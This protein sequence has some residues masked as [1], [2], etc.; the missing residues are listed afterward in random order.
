M[1]RFIPLICLFFSLVSAEDFFPTTTNDDSFPLV[2][3]EG[4]PNAIIA[5]C[6]N[7]ITGDFFDRQCDLMLVGGEPLVL[8]RSYSSSDTSQGGLCN[9]WHFNLQGILECAHGSDQYVL[10]G[11]FGSE[12]RFGKLKGN[13]ASLSKEMFKKG[14]TNNSSA[15]I[16]GK[17]NLKNYLLKCSD[18][19]A[20]HCTLIKGDGSCEIFKRQER[21]YHK[22]AKAYLLQVEKKAS[23][24]ERHYHYNDKDQLSYVAMVSG[25]S[26]DLPVDVLQTL[27]FE[28]PSKSLN[29]TR[30]RVASGDGRSVQY[31]FSR[32]KADGNR[33]SYLREVQRPNAPTEKY[34]YEKFDGSTRQ[35]LIEKRVGE[36]VM[37][38]CYCKT[39]PNSALLKGKDRN[40]GKV[41]TLF[42]PIG[43][44][45]ALLPLYN[46]HYDEPDRDRDGGVCHVFDAHKIRTKYTWDKNL[47]LV[48][49]EKMNSSDQL[50]V[51]D[52]LYWGKGGNV[53]NLV[54]RVYSSAETG[55]LFCK[56]YSYDQFGNIFKE[57][58]YGHLTGKNPVALL[59]D[60]NGTP[61]E[62]GCD[63]HEKSF[64]YSQDGRNLLL[65]ETEG[66]R[67]TAYRYYDGTDLVA[68][69]YI[70][71]QGKI[72][73]RYCYTYDSNSALASEIVDDGTSSEPLDLSNVTYRKLRL[74]TPRKTFPFGVPDTEEEYYQDSS[75]QQILL[76]ALVNT[77]SLEGHL[78][79][80]DVYDSNRAFRYTLFW[81]Y[82]HLGQ[83]TKEVDALGQV[84]YREYDQYGNLK[85]EQGPDLRVHKQ[86]TYDFSNRLIQED[87]VH[88][89]RVLS[90]HYR[91]NLL[92]QKIAAI[93]CYGNETIYVY[94]EFGRVVQIISPQVQ[95]QN[96]QKTHAT[97]SFNY[98]PMGC[99]CLTI[100]PNG[101]ATTYF[102]TARGKPYLIKH[103]DGTEE[104]FTYLLHGPLETHTR[105]NG[106]LTKYYY[107][108]QDRV[109]RTEFY[110]SE[111]V[112]KSFTTLTY[113]A[114]HLLSETDAMG[115]Q[116][117]YTYDVSGRM[118][119][120][121]SK[122]SLTTYEYDALG[123]LVKKASSY[124][125]EPH[126]V[127]INRFVY[128]LL[129]RT[130]Q[131]TTEDFLGNIL[132]QKNYAYDVLGRVILETTYNQ[133]GS[134]TIETRYDSY[135]TPIEVIDALRNCTKTEIRF[136]YRNKE[137]VLV[138]YKEVIDPLGNKTI[139]IKDAL[140]REVV[141]L[142]KNAMG[143]VTQQNISYYDQNSNRCKVVEVVFGQGLPQEITHVWTYNVMNAVVSMTEAYAEPE[144]RTTVYNYNALGQLRSTIKPSGTSIVHFY[145]SDGQLESKLASDAS[146]S[147]RYEYD[148]NHN[149]V[150][151]HDEV[152]KRSTLRT[153]AW[154]RLVEEKQATGHTVKYT[155]D[156]LGR[157]VSLTLPDQSSVVYS[158]N[159]SQLKNIIRYD[160][161]GKEQYRHT[162][163]QFDLSGNCLEETFLKKAGTLSQSFDMKG[164]LVS[165][166]T[167]HTL[168]QV[169][170][171]DAVG[172]LLSR[173]IKDSSGATTCSYA[174]DE[175]Y[176]LKSEEGIASN[177]F[178][179]DSAY[180]R[181]AKNGSASTFNALNQNLS[182]GYLYDRDGRLV[183]TPAAVY[184]Y[185]ALDR[186]T[187]VT[188][189]DVT[190]IYTYDAFNRRMSKSSTTF[191]YDGQKEIGA[192]SL[193]KLKEFRVLAPGSSEIGSAVAIEIGDEVFAPVHDFS[194][195]VIALIEGSGN[196]Y[197]NYRYS[198]FGE[199]LTPSS[200]PWRFASKR[201]D[202]ES[203]L[204]YFGQRYYDPLQGCWMTPDPIG[205]PGGF[206]LYA[207]VYN[208]PYYYKDP[209]GRFAFAL[210]IPAFSGTFGI[211]GFTF[212]FITFE[213]LLG[214][215]VGATIGYTVYEINKQYDRR[216]DD[217]FTRMEMAS[218]V[219][220]EVED[221]QKE[222]RAKDPE[223]KGKRK[224]FSPDKNAE[225]AHSTFR[226]D[227]DTG[228]IT[229]YE[230]FKPQTNHRNPNL[231]ESEKRYDN[232]SSSEGHFN[233]VIDKYI[234]V[235][236]VHEPH[237]PGGVRVPENWEIP[238]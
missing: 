207:Y 166:T 188:K 23:G 36:Q 179:F 75:G 25:K 8:E 126:E 117:N 67:G 167:K 74:M 211:G 1:L 131:E 191:I 79:R 53:G 185:D 10:K 147:Y 142:R 14:F 9:G 125:S 13:Q 47:R 106:C 84:T 21:D 119:S 214:I 108:Y 18:P 35:R 178:A 237:T 44:T 212:S 52:K 20:R 41:Q 124:G 63:C 94:D 26:Q 54:A 132:T 162:Y 105:R 134:N 114:F 157:V 163:D 151:T 146:F 138:P 187:S 81:E 235:P 215:G 83:A 111:G 172:N 175:L 112:L 7:V 107:D 198:S 161:H 199:G 143:Q 45:D 103:P 145:S 19:Q 97:I 87:E 40:F 135:G 170:E 59:V 153:Y 76:K 174:Y 3:L 238:R 139:S 92:G 12:M 32:F 189:N 173:E 201:F 57:S 230:T 144:Q 30:L 6:V 51:A 204:V 136:D 60:E 137:G 203:G 78:V 50:Y 148:L 192:V 171:Y 5:D 58:F 24:V 180:N 194:G 110:T 184:T 149:I 226:R 71:F 133:K 165:R 150:A 130:M 127:I 93:D 64:V 70:L 48:E 31:L 208:N 100:D 229:H 33:A 39:V 181:V 37:Q 141:H 96:G 123:R 86:F 216:C 120:V 62:T 158:Y 88:L 85:K 217:Y 206:N 224:R 164:R 222:T 68:V 65:I 27:S 219:E 220:G 115:H 221:K 140:G 233:K 102:N 73:Q 80:Q 4:E 156:L 223:K 236:H 225:G 182:K 183:Q 118:Q 128:D 42:A 116:T 227:P 205:Y 99:R 232:G 11:A 169:K 121:S 22:D 77:Y 2:N 231:W 209:D 197:E 160:C 186:L 168:E 234:N 218:Q 17:T 28:Y 159:S 49:I 176:Q 109:V 155:Y 196:L 61:I 43:Q 95:D 228:E 90:T 195:N 66:D 193:G 101:Q 98:D 122:G 177:T 91:Y 210:L 69:K 202:A 213:S 29:T 46:F 152:L 190:T 16:S 113:D 34:R 82:N 72:M 38:V 104:K 89:D 15:T 200:N 56:T 129:D 154:D 55:P